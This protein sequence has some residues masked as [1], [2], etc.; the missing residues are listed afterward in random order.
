M[1][2]AGQG[3]AELMVL[4]CMIYAF[5]KAAALFLCG[6]IDCEKRWKK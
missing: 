3:L 2:D 4:V 6:L 1:D 5:A